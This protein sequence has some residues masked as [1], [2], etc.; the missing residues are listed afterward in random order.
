[1][2]VRHMSHIA[3]QCRV[4]KMG[5]ADTYNSLFL[6]VYGQQ[7]LSMYF[8]SPSHNFNIIDKSATNRRLYGL[9]V[10]KQ[11]ARTAGH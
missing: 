7:G 3:Y 2:P 4:W 6:S 10:A 8:G 9:T 1:M 5:L 11:S